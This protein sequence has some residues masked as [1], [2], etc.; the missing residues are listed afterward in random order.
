MRD[1]LEPAIREL[2]GQKQ[3]SGPGQ[4]FHEFA[5]FC[6][7]QL[8][9][10]EAA[11]DMERI[12]TVMDRKLQEYHEFTKLSKTDKSKGMR[13]TY[14]RSARRAKGWYNLDHAEYERMRKGR[15]QFLRQC[16][17]NYLL[18]LFASDEYNNDALRVFS[19]WLEYSD[20]DLANTAVQ[21]YLNDVP[22]GKF[23]L[24]MNQL[25][26]R[27]QGE[28]N[29]FQQ[30]LMALVFRICVE[31]PYHGMHQ[32][33]AIQMKVGAITR[34]DVVRAK[35]ESARSRQ[36]AATALANALSNDKRARSYWS[37]IFQSNEIY[38]HLAMFKGEKESTQQGREL[39]L[40]RY[41]ESK[42]LVNKVPKLNVPPATLQ[43]EVRPNMNYSDLPRI[44]S[45]KSTMS[46]ANGLS[47]PKIITA[48][49]TDG[50]PYKQ[51]FKSGNDD[52]RQDAIMEQV[53]DQVSRL[54]KNHTATRI[55][56][57]GI[58]TYK[59]PSALDSFRLDGVVQNT[60]PLHLW[61]M[62]A[63]EKYYPNDYKP[64]RC[65]KEIGACQQDSLT[66]RVKV[67]QKIADNFHP[68]LRYFLLERFEDPDEW[69]ERRV[70][71]TRSTAAISVLGHVLGLGDRHCHN[72]LLD[73]KTG[74]V[75]HIDLGVSFEAGR[76][77]P[78]PEVVPFRLTRDLVDAMG[79]TKTEGRVPPMLRV[80]HGHAP[81]GAR[82]HHDAAQCAALRSARQLERDV[83]QGQAD[84]GGQCRGGTKRQPR[85][86]RASR[87]EARRPPRSSIR[88][89][90]PMTCLSR[91]VT[92]RRRRKT[93]LVKRAEHLAL[94]RRSL[95][96][97][98]ST[99][100]T[101]NELIQQ[102][103]DERN[104]AVLYMGWA[105]YA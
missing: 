56:N 38:H 84:A 5:L 10:P 20:T 15:E 24:L 104:L 65:R 92:R 52:L 18:S 81:R 59:S 17:E 55:R 72:I 16:L 26:S 27:L 71:Y 63:H 3:G 94:S 54:L 9:S 69:F 50:K 76:V 100:A 47:A 89:P 41:K 51:L 79:Y 99:K 45:F 64:D 77:L 93:R 74:E 36:K 4:V 67:W 60:I 34:E 11:E 19:L 98:L 102:S 43:I 14:H 22:S 40:D 33:F 6:D 73:E 96:K 61:V 29:D 53:F 7:K 95:S 82:E 44:H 13:E 23:A 30:L 8:Q 1:Y 85:G 88:L 21:M 35:D 42:E 80:H 57:L 46:I 39:P 32:I 86:R 49:G 58:R 90:C 68:V 70:A 75:V 97:T 66:T 103:T 48:K 62:P 78:V 28:D 2:K 12:K 83:D 101:V 37:S 25:S 105:S 91:T 87:R 31:H